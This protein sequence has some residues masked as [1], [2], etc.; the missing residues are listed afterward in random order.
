[1]LNFNKLNFTE[2]I[3]NYGVLVPIDKW[4]ESVINGEFTD[5]DGLGNWVKNGK[6]TGDYDDSI[7]DETS[8]NE[9]KKYGIEAVCWFNK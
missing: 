7:F 3:P 2:D 6:R 8:I 4:E 1:M 9:A 5:D